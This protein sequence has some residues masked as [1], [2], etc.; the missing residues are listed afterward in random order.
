[1]GILGLTIQQTSG[2]PIISKTWTDKLASF[3]KIDPILTAG[4]MS[5]ITNF[6]DSFEQNI[7]FIQLS[8]KVDSNSNGI[9]AVLNYFSE[10]IMIC[11]TEPYLF[12]DKVNLKL[13]WIHENLIDNKMEALRKGDVFNLTEEEEIYIEDVLFDKVSR[14][15]IE[16]KKEDIIA[17]L[18]DIEKYFYQEDIQGFSI[19]SFDNSIIFTHNINQQDLQDLLCNMGKGGRVKDWEVQYKP[20]WIEKN[21]ILIS[22]TNSAVKIPVT[23]I[24]SRKSIEICPQRDQLYSAEVPLYYYII[25]D[26]DCSIGPIMEK[27]NT[28]LH[29][30][31]VGY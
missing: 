31:L 23:K 20:V 30:I 2:M 16:E 12:L 26:T 15:L 25:T 14:L 5:A 6:A 8:P 1:M 4:F 17:A 19:N 22:Y 3:D 28:T 7:D 27:L 21:P 10:V 11:F 13:R 24:V 18:L 9:S 29:P